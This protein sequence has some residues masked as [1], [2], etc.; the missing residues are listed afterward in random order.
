[1]TLQEQ[2]NDNDNEILLKIK[3]SY[4]NR[5]LRKYKGGMCSQKNNVFF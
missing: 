1:M 2:G 3:K 4:R 5:V